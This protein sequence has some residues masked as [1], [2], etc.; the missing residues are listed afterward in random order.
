MINK[1]NINE[2]ENENKIKS[3]L[4]Y[5]YLDEKKIIE[6]INLLTIEQVIS[7][8]SNYIV[9]ILIKNKGKTKLKIDSIK[10]PLY[11]NKVPIIKIEDYLIRLVKFSKMEISTLVLTFIYIKRFIDKEHFI[12]A[13]NNIFRLIITCSILA[14][15]FNENRTF[16]NSFYAKIGGLEVEDLNNLEYNVFSRLNF[17]LR[18]LDSEFYEIISEIYKESLNI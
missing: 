16:K 17:N 7:F 10:D 18:V 3:N 13:F 8:I 1:E 2:K 5:N 12:I 4:K 11:S 15:K 14:I 9:D 6:I